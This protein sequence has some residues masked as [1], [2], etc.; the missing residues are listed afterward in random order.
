M[1]V[2]IC[3]VSAF[4]WAAFDLT[5]K[6]TLE[7]ISSINL[8][9]IFTV[10]QLI[11]FFIWLFLEDFS[12]NLT[13]YLLPGITLIIIGLFSALL[14]LKAIKQSDLSLTI[15]LL[16]LSPMFSSLFSFFF[17]NEQLSNI[18]YLGIFLIILGTLILYSKKLTIYEIIKSFKIILKNS[19]AKLM[20]LV[21]I[22]WSLT[23]VLDK[24]CLKNSSINIHGFVQSLGM[25]TLL[26]FLFKKDKVQTENTKK[27]WRII[28]LTVFIGSTATIL[29]FYAIL[30]NYVPIMESIK[31]SVG[32][33]S[34]VFFGKIFFNEE[35]NK[36]KVVGVI[37]LSIGVY[38]IV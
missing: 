31:R 33:L 20:V 17:L 28:L 4:F 24:I 26:I 36:P 16:S 9:L 38:F 29:Q 18:Q 19:S 23:P 12:I 32:Q 27:N 22:I 15:P 11:I 13:P 35:I 30:T 14:F 3:I 6:L 25:I 37:V 34:S 2:L 8:L 1:P 7:K 10:T 5:R 21:S